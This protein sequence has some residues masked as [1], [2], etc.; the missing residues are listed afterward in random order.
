[1]DNCGGPSKIKMVLWLALYSVVMNCF[2]QVE[3]IFFIIGHTKNDWYHKFCAMR[4]MISFFVQCL[5]I[6]FDYDD[7]LYNFFKPFKSGTTPVNHYFM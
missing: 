4:W 7:M 6:F 3:F 1:M 5:L 2:K